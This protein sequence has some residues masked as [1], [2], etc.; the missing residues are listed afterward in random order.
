MPSN[1]CRALRTQNG[2]QMVR[3][4]VEAPFVAVLGIDLHMKGDTSHLARHV[5]LIKVGV[6][7]RL[8]QITLRNLAQTFSQLTKLGIACIIVFSTHVEIANE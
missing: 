3:S 7:D 2:P 1:F 8:D 5:F 6:L 4:Q